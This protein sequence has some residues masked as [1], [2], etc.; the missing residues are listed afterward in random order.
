M[1]FTDRPVHRPKPR[2]SAR[3]RALALAAAGLSALASAGCGFHP[4]YGERSRAAPAALNHVEVELIE[5]RTGQMLRN[6]LLSRFHP[7]GGSGDRYSLT[8]KIVETLQDL[9]IRKDS[10]ATRANLTLAANFAVRSLPDRK[11]LMA[12]NAN[13]VNSY[14]ILTSDF[15][16]LSARAD[17]RRRGVRQLADQ[18]EERV[19]IWLLQTGGAAVPGVQ[20]KP[21]TGATPGTFPANTPSPYPRTLAPTPSSP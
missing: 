17:A 8:V 12:N 3:R 11:L 20:E 13:S 7:R 19:S 10:V 14:N 5:G 1:S 2:R 15:A 21:K 18:I 6:Q 9:G 16:T 4:L